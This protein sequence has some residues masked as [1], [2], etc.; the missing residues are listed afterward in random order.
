MAKYQFKVYTGDEYCA[1]TDANIF[2]TL[3]GVLDISREYR[4]NGHISGNAF[5]RNQCD[6][7]DLDISEDVGDVYEIELRS[8]CMHG[9]S[10][11]LLNSIEITSPSGTMAKFRYSD[12]ITDKKKRTLSATNIK[13]EDKVSNTM[14]KVYS[15]SYSVPANTKVGQ[16]FCAEKTL[17]YHLSESKVKDIKT[18]TKTG[19]SGGTKQVKANIE[20]V[21]GTEVKEMTQVD[22]ST[23]EKDTMSVEIEFPVCPEPKTYYLVY[24][25]V[26]NKHIITIGNYEIEVS[27]ARECSEGGYI[28]EADRKNHPEIES[29]DEY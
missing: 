12:W 4:L 28:E 24:N 29:I 11:W 9:G 17:G 26:T 20:F 5:E 16:K 22:S 2:V 1:G 14:Q 25:I 21:L 10:D 27:E 6:S 8:D 15:G 19:V 13:K 7:F 18:Q 3:H 23:S